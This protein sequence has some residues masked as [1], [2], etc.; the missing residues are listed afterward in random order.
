[1]GCFNGRMAIAAQIPIA[2]IVC[3]DNDEIRSFSQIF[4]A[5]AKIATT[6]E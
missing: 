3:K 6:K 4:L 1:M 5:L 2:Q